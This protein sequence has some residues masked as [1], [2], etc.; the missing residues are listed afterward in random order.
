M[1]KFLLKKS[2]I[3]GQ[4]IF[5]TKN[6]KKGEFVVKLTGKKIKWKYD[7]KKDR[8]YCANWTG[9][10]KDL[11]IDPDFPLSNIN[12]SCDPNLGIKG[13]IMFYAIRD[14]KIGEEFTFDYSTSE[15]E[16]DWIMKCN[17]GSKNCRKTMTA[18][19]FLPLKVFNAHLPYIPTYYQK[20]YKSYNKNLKNI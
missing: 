5:A 8:A 19:Q 2:K 7:E 11:W 1:D 16:I 20:V 12:H 17:C 13:K 10:E 4:G 9:I 15:E 6:Y 14:I 3:Q 18:I